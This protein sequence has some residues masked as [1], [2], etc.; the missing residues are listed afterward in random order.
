MRLSTAGRFLTGLA[1]ILLAC[2]LAG[3]GAFASFTSTSAASESVASGTVTIALGT[4]GASTNRLDV[5]ADGLAPGDS[6]ERGFDLRNL[7]SLQLDAISLTTTATASSLL[8]TDATD[9]L[10][11]EIDRC[12]VPWTESG[13]SPAFVYSCPGAVSSVLAENPVIQTD[14]PLSNLSSLAPG[15]TDHLLLTAALP[16]TAGNNLQGQS[17]TID[18]AFTGAH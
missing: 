12:S 4:T 5:D 8:D 2:F 13:A 18:Y 10:Q 7:G 15:A 11:I 6:F 14:V 17:S 9:G 16:M 1:L 3:W